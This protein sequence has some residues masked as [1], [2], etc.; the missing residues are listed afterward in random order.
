M[1]LNIKNA[2]TEQLAAE[3]ARLAGESKTQA[4]KVAL[5]ERRDRLTVGASKASR[6]ERLLAFLAGDIWS[7]IPSDVL[8]KPL[9]R[10]EREAVLGYGPQGV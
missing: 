5:R 3:V 1:A 8:G 2:E 7:R 9:S 10:A 6:T 4:I